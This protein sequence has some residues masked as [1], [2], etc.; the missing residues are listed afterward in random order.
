MSR[1]LQVGCGTRAWPSFVNLDRLPLAGVD[2]VADL[3]RPL[4]FADGCFDEAHAEHVLEHVTD[5]VR[6]FEELVRVT[7]VGGRVFVAVPHFSSVSAYQ[8]PTHRRFFGYFS[9]D[10]FTEDGLFNFYSRA[11]VRI[12]RRRIRFYWIKNDR[13]QVPSPTVSALVN[14][15]P[16][17]YERFFCWWLPSNEVT[18]ELEVV[19]H[20]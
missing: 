7:R 10:Y 13:R 20:A 1:K 8:D 9:F 16:L 3:D 17:L 18:F 15:W 19:R 14:L 2:V 12:V 4:P 11:R 6:T 5:L